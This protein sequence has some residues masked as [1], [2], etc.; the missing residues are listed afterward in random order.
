MD[1]D[2]EVR[3]NV[4]RRICMVMNKSRIDFSSTPGY[5]DFL[6]ERE[7]V[8]RRFLELHATQTL[9]EAAAMREEL[10]R[11]LAAYEAANAEQI[12]ASRSLEDERKKERIKEVVRQEGLFFERVNAEYANRDKVLS[13]PLEAQYSLLTPAVEVGGL[14]A[15]NKESNGVRK[16]R[17]IPSSGE[18]VV[19][20]AESIAATLEASGSV[21]LWKI[22]ALDSLTRSLGCL[23]I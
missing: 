10:N 14:R 7:D 1:V 5:D 23:E 9:P 6:D 8:I 4:R 21:G 11:E 17:L 22:K 2:D 18:T 16:T 19:P 20:V 12:L 13:H 15:S 3:G